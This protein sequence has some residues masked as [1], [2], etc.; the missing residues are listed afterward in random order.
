M[1]WSFVV[2]SVGG[3]HD[4]WDSE[5]SRRAIRTLG[6]TTDDETIL[7]HRGQRDTLWQIDNY[8]FDEGERPRTSYAYCERKLKKCGICP[9]Y[10]L[11]IASYDGYPY[12]GLGRRGWKIWPSFAARGGNETVVKHPAYSCKISLKQCF[13][14][15][16]GAAQTASEIFKHVAFRTPE[17]GDCST[18]SFVLLGLY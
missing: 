5:H 16:E 7:V 14:L 1:L 18:S 8:L 9:T 6:G 17:C 15:P 10:Y 12:S 4:E 13:V 3:D 11:F 2:A